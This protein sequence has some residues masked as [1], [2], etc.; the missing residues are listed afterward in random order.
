MMPRS[1]AVTIAS[2]ALPVICGRLEAGA[3]YRTVRRGGTTD[4]VLLATVEG[5]GRL[6]RPAERDVFAEPGRIA[7]IEPRT[8]HDYGTDPQAGRWSLRWAHIEPRLDWVALLDWPTAAPGIRILEVD[9]MVRGRVVQ[10]L[11][12]AISALGTGARHA[13]LFAANAVEEALLWCDT[14]NPAGP[15]LDSRLVAVLEY[16]GEN[17]DT[18]HT[19]TSLARV[20]GLSPSRLAHLAAAQLGTSLMARVEHQ[21]M[22]HARHLLAI[23]ELPVGHIARRVGYTDPLY[24]TRRFRARTGMSPSEFRTRAYEYSDM[25]GHRPSA[26]D[27]GSNA[28]PPGRTSSTGRT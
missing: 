14:R 13:A 6:R 17:L 12:R 4:W 21:R 1:E 24:F 5:C 23:T 15:V 27:Q 25:L 26:E 10:A 9:E 19:P 7:L 3:D 18:P 11:D 8:P 28:K 2:R 16:I 20:C 22:E